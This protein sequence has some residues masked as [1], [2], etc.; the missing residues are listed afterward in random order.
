MLCVRKRLKS[1]P[2]E[3][4]EVLVLHEFHIGSNYLDIEF[5]EFFPLSS[6]DPETEALCPWYPNRDCR[7][8]GPEAEKYMAN[9]GIT[10]IVST[11]TYPKMAMES[12]H[13]YLQY[14][15]HFTTF[16]TLD[17]GVAPVV[18]NISRGYFGFKLDERLKVLRTGKTISIL[19]LTNELLGLN[20]KEAFLE[21]NASYDRGIDVDTLEAKYMA[22]D[23]SSKKFLVSN[24]INYKMNDSRPVLEQYNELLGILGRFTQHMM[25]MDES[26]QVSCIIDKPP[27]SW[28]DFNTP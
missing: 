18:F 9:E 14:L 2:Q 10:V 25:N 3:G 23:A 5:D 11:A 4:K 19:A 24:F 20:Y 27:S 6:V 13:N 12:G 1:R 28:K 22:E 26:I 8:N 15:T 16:D 7:D 17:C 21:L